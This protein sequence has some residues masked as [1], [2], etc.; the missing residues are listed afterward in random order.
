MIDKESLSLGGSEKENT[1][2]LKNAQDLDDRQRGDT[3]VEESG[4][5]EKIL[6]MLNSINFKMY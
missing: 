2:L 6:G 3:E 1:S 4:N 5:P